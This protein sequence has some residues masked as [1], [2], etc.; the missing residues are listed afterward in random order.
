MEESRRKFLTRVA[1]VTPV[2]LTAVVR[3]AY[4]CSAYGG[5]DKPKPM[6]GPKTRRGPGKSW[7]GD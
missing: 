4:A 1:Y 2:I 3:P 6:C 7:W 5:R